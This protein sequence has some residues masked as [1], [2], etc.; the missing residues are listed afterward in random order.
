MNSE[1]DQNRFARALEALQRI[2]TER[3]IPI[4]IIGGLGAIRYGYPASTQD[5]GVSVS[6]TQL[7]SFIDVAPGYGFKVAWESKTGW[8]TLM[9]GDVEINVVPEGGRARDS[10]PTLIPGPMQMGVKSGLQYASIETWVE[11]KISSGRQKD[12]AHIVEV[13]KKSAPSVIDSIQRHLARVHATYAV[14]FSQLSAMAAEEQN[15]EKERR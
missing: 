14:Q 11:L 1:L 9:H 8:H 7:Q 6:K 4:A 3:N 15:Q 2:A 5:I 12:Q 10:S 13:L